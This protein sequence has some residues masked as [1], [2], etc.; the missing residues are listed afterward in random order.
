[1]ELHCLQRQ[2]QKDKDKSGVRRTRINIQT[3]MPE[4]TVLTHIKHG[5]HCLPFSLHI[6]TH[7]RV[8]QIYPQ[9]SHNEEKV[10]GW[11][12]IT[13]AVKEGTGQLVHLCSL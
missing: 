12:S 1:M 8:A 4:Q 6:L 7:H 11:G 13:Y 9:K 5:L 3:S 10:G 2:G